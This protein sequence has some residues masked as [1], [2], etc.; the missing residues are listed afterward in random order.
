MKIYSGFVYI[1]AS[2]RNGTL[3][4]G[5]TNDLARRVAEHKASINPGFT[6]KYDVK[7]LVYYESF[8]DIRQA[9]AR[10]KQLKGWKRVWKMAL[11]EKV[12]PWW[13]DLSEEIGVDEL[14][15]QAIKVEYA[16]RLPESNSE[17]F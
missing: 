17:S 16:S 15:I 4:I 8:N 14:F 11:I 3:Y 13:K 1:M 7:M 10:E 2:R 12:N 9:I 5:V 6:A